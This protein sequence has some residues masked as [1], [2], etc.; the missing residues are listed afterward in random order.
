MA[1]T[2]IDAALAQY[3]ASIPWL[4]S[5]AAAQAAL[6][7][8]QYLLVNRPQGQ[9]DQGSELNYESLAAEKAD[10]QKFLGGT[11][12]RAFGRSRFNT[13]RFCGGSSIE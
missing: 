4:T 9:T 11:A 5:Q 2:S 6:E 7:A 10:I 13:A 3:N 12:P 1:L 8:I